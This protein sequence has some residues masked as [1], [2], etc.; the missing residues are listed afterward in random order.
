[1]FCQSHK[2]FGV[3]V[4]VNIYSTMLPSPFSNCPIVEEFE[5]SE[6]YTAL[7]LLHMN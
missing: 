7:L 3:T 2:Q 5:A 1:M 6:N 4:L